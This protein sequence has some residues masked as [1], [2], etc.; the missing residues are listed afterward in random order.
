MLY[1]IRELEKERQ[2]TDFVFRIL[3][4]LSNVN[5]NTSVSR[6]MSW[7]SSASTPAIPR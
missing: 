1:K 3:L 7:L 5:L 4:R 2:R 6:L